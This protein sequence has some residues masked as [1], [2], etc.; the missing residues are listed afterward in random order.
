MDEKELQ[1]LRSVLKADEHQSA[2]AQKAARLN[3]IS[4]LTSRID[5]SR[6]FSNKTDEDDI[7]TLLTNESVWVSSWN[8]VDE[9][10]NKMEI[11]QE[12]KVTRLHA[13]TMDSDVAQ[14]PLS[15]QYLF[16]NMFSGTALIINSTAKDLA[17][18]VIN[19][20][21]L[22]DALSGKS[23]RNISNI[24]D[25]VEERTGFNIMR[26]KTRSSAITLEDMITFNETIS[27]CVYC[28]EDS[29]N[30]RNI[31]MYDCTSVRGT[32]RD[33]VF[34]YDIPRGR[35]RDKLTALEVKLQNEYL[36]WSVIIV[37]RMLL[38][39]H[40][41][42]Y[43]TRN[44]SIDTTQGFLCKKKS[45]LAVFDTLDELKRVTYLWVKW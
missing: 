23:I 41:S 38:W 11:E 31:G 25:G 17:T 4:G 26:P 16:N 27:Q 37:P 10:M 33:H 32:V 40:N 19:K 18:G 24:F 21:K 36:N 45:I 1:E 2:E 44:L 3:Q 13:I 29:Y 5:Y 12:R 30:R 39:S 9:E 22:R 15:L 34:K 6:A 20:D 14:H 7:K 43:K 28:G 35:N 8:E 42:Q